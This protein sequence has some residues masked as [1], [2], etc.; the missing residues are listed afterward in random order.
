MVEPGHPPANSR[1]PQ[2]RVFMT[3]N[4]ET[5]QLFGNPLEGETGHVYHVEPTGPYDRDIEEAQFRPKKREDFDSR[6]P[7]RVIR[8]VSRN[9]G[10]GWGQQ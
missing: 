10:E 3:T 6:S 2:S 5:A 4:I 1:S 7:L 9:P 8:E